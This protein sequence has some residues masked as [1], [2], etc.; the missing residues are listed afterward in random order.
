[1]SPQRDG[2]E[3]VG[4]DNVSFK[5]TVNSVLFTIKKLN[6]EKSLST[7]LFKIN[8][9]SFLRLKYLTGSG[10]VWLSSFGGSDSF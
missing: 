7:K 10:R 6:I 1:M 2:R 8:K 3:R 4:E 5:S 9:Y